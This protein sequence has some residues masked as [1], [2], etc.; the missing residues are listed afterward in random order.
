MDLKEIAEALNQSLEAR[1]WNFKV[2]QGAV[3]GRVQDWPAQLEV[4]IHP[5][6]ESQQPL[7]GLLID[8]TSMPLHGERFLDVFQVEREP[9]LR[10]LP[11]FQVRQVMADGSWGPVIDGRGFVSGFGPQAAISRKASLVIFDCSGDERGQTLIQLFQEESRR[12][13]EAGDG[14][15]AILNRLYQRTVLE[16]KT[17]MPGLP[18]ELSGA[19][20]PVTARRTLDEQDKEGKYPW[21]R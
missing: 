11:A 2:A 1:G 10:P 13:L 15:A 14:A 4:V 6:G 19:G 21:R 7:M 16:R 5:G 20:A 9:V 3:R 17:P 18:E 8:F 12:I